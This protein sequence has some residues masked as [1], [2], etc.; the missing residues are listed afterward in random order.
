MLSL[1][2]GVELVQAISGIK[3][4]EAT[5]PGYIQ[6]LHDALE[7]WETGAKKYLLT[8]PALHVD[9]TGLRINGKN[10]WLHVLTD[11]SLTL[12]FLHRK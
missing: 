6:R 3:L 8:S 2:R 7:P 11:S 1:C 12:K 9:E 4:S 5:C 10:Q